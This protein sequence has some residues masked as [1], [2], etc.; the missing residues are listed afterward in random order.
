MAQGAGF[1]VNP[2]RS[3]KAPWFA[4]ANIARWSNFTWSTFGFGIGGQ[5]LDIDVLPD[6]DLL[7]GGTFTTSGGAAPA[8]RSISKRF[9]SVVPADSTCPIV[10]PWESESPN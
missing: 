8:R 1:D 10:A 4:A 9:A 7:V 6:G 2:L 3:G 5:V